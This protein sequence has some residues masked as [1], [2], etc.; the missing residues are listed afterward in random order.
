MAPPGRIGESGRSRTLIVGVGSTILG[1]DGVGVR[2]ARE[3]VAR[4]V[5]AG[6]DV[7]ELGTGGLGL[8]DHVAGYDR[9]IVLDA[10]VTGAPPGTVHVSTDNAIPATLHVGPGHEADLRTT[11][12]LG[13]KLVGSR[14]PEEVV[15]LAV[16]ARDARSFSEHL[17][18]EVEA[19]VP[20][21]LRKVEQF[22]AGDPEPP[23]P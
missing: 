5:P 12:A 23:S 22:L 10:I 4:G 6:V 19:A 13:R 21:A 7:I 18:P 14:M 16:E 20:G 15:V 2:L 9:L 8:L 11:L 3:L 17:T 1:D